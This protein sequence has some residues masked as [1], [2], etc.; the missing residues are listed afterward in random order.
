MPS[1]NSFTEIISAFLDQKRGFVERGLGP[2][3]T[4][5]S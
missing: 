2:Q 3:K 4:D 5:V 1:A